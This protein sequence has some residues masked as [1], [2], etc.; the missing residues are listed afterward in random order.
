ML[1]VPAG[2]SIAAFVEN[3]GLPVTPEDARLSPFLN[4]VI[5][6]VKAGVGSLY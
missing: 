1:Y 6:A 5:V 2:L 3:A 4:P